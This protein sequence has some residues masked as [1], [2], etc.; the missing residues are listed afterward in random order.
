MSYDGL[1]LDFDGVV[2][3]VL[4]DDRRVPAFRDRIAEELREY[5]SGGFD[6]DD[7][8]ADLAHGVTFDKLSRLSNTAEIPEEDLWR[9]R[10]DA[11]AD[12]LDRAA[13][14]GHKTPYDDVTALS[15]LDHPVGIVSNNQ[16]RVV[17]SVSDR[18][19]LA[20]QF[21][22]IRARDPHPESLRRKKPEPTFLEGSIRDLGVE[23]PLFVGD[24]E[25]DVRAGQRA[26][27]DTVLLRREHNAGRRIDAEP[28]YEVN[29]LD[30]V[31][32]LF[33]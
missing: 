4:P 9:A 28:T 18:F 19:G 2:V 31:V 5:R 16:R 13:R 17:E 29:R 8:A 7:L 21:G 26:G 20:E 3:N 23:N 22:T 12:V 32:D 33:E 30:A 27:V 24:K 1:L 14:D 10:D 25:T 6:I 15:A 11:L